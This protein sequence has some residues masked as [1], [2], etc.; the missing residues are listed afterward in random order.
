MAPGAVAVFVTTA[1]CLDP[2]DAPGPH[3]YSGAPPIARWSVAADPALLPQGA[4]IHVE[5]LGPRVVDDI[6]FAIKGRRLDLY[7]SDCREAL[8]WG[9]Q[10]RSVAVLQVP[11]DLRPTAA[12]APTRL[13]G[14]FPSVPNGGDSGQHFTDPAPPHSRGPLLIFGALLL[15]IG[16]LSLLDWLVRTEREEPGRLTPGWRPLGDQER[17]ERAR[18]VR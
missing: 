16:S 17:V 10:K 11:Q 18:G 5:G 1:Y 12:A 7:V 13:D 3:T 9:R 15:L 4:R 14:I 2:K 6:G 8:R